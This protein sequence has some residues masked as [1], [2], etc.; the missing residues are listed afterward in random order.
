LK[1]TEGCRAKN[2]RSE[3]VA[4]DLKCEEAIGEFVFV[5]KKWTSVHICSCGNLTGDVG[6]S[7]NRQCYPSVIFRRCSNH[8]SVW[9]SLE[10]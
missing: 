9:T 3:A 7:N 1:A 10:I 2:K 8:R 5:A 6:V 4:I